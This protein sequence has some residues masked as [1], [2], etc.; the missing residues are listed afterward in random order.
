MKCLFSLIF[1]SVTI[2]TSYCQTS[3]DLK[4]VNAHVGDS[5]T[6]VGKV[7]GV[8]YLTNTKEKSTFVYIGAAYPSQVLTVL[9]LSHVRS[10][11]MLEPTQE[12]LNGKE[13]ILRGKIKLYKGK[14]QLV[15][16][17]PSQ[18]QV[19]DESGVI[20]PFRNNP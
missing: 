19:T 7:F 17:D 4:D 13:V 15:V 3:I 9:V 14:P 2:L 11:M 20:L 8:K 5:V 16:S 1:L 18:F 6:F 10:E 12:N